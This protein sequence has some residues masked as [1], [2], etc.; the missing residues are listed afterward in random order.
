MEVAAGAGPSRWRARGLAW[1]LALPLLAPLLLLLASW[2]EPQS[3]VWSHLRESVLGAAV[4][5]TLVLAALVG[6]IVSV[7]GIGLAWLCVRCEFPARRWLEWALVL[8]LALPGYVAAFAYVGL[9]DYAG[10]LQSAWRSVSGSRALL[11]EARSVPGASMILGLV[12]YPY[13]YLLARAAFQRQGAQAF[14]AARSLGLGPWTA[15]FRV[16]LPL[17]RPAWAAGLTLALLETLADFGAVSILGVDTITTTIYKTW[18]GLTSLPAAAQLSCLLLMLVIALLGIDGLTRGGGRIA[19]RSA[20]PPP[21]LPLR[22]VR[23]LAATAAAASVVALGFGLPVMRLVAWA[24]ASTVPIGP[25][26][27]VAIN[28]L[29]IGLAVAL[30]VLSLG[31]GFALLERRSGGDRWIALPVFAANLGYAV[32]G[33]VIAVASMLLLLHL[34][35][36][37]AQLTGWQW[38]LSSSLGA[39][40][41]ALTLRFLRVGHGSVDAGL[42]TLRPDLIE[43]ARVLGVGPGGRLR[44]LV[45]PLLRPALF[46]ALLLVMVETMKEM[47]AT[48]MLRPFGWDTL[49]VKIHGYTSEGLW[50]EAAWPALLLVAVGM[51][52]IWLL[53]RAHR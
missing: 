35:S 13:V 39:T 48:L 27:A 34:E 4:G 46:A 9:L 25:L 10:P 16:A 6:I 11:F 26:V 1:L 37:I 17:V 20:R 44:L 19:E 22:G 3:A 2:R 49:A 38:L 45:L 43:S 21:R 5:N 41:L 31:L 50:H 40:V 52:P 36:A 42:R 15:F 33:T 8:P 47:P 24:M 7:I 32:P 18:F 14:D 53:V 51:L 30:A 23:A 28:T 12:L 29:A